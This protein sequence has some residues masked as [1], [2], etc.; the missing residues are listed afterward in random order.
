[1]ATQSDPRPIAD[2]LSVKGRRVIVTGGATGIGFGIARAFVESGAHV[3]ITG[4]RPD[5]LAKAAQ[6]LRALARDGARVAELVADVT[7]P[8]D[9]A[10]TVA[11][12]ARELG[13]LDVLV[14]NAGSGEFK[15]LAAGTPQELR[16]N[17]ETNVFGVYEL[18]QAALPELT[19]SRAG[20][21]VSISS[22]A[23]L[24]GI[25]GA[26]IY[27]SGKGAVTSFARTLAVELAASPETR[28]ITSNSVSPGPFESELFFTIPQEMRDGIAQSTGL[29]RI[30]QAHP[31][32]GGLLVLL[33]SDSG[34]YITGQDIVVDGGAIDKY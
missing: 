8:G 9:A 30:G 32:L 34:A 18:T 16:K 26:T 4:R 19:K 3:L 21:V 1:M 33:A 15:P 20:R 25:P 29:K 22:I 2:Y 13:G 31:E 23:G 27:G 11:A 24:R 6:E 28:H 7:A 17:F 10:R 14:N 12:A 5:R